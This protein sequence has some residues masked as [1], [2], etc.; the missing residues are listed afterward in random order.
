MRHTLLGAAALF[1]VAGT[2]NA[3]TYDID[4]SH[5]YPNFT[6]SHLGYSTTYGRFGSTS[7]TIEMDLAKKTG[8]V[9]IVIDAASID[10]GFKKRD[11]H[12]RS[13]DF[14]NVNEFPQIT[15]KSTK[16]KFTGDS[17]AKVEGKLTITGVTKDVTLD[18]THIHCGPHPFNKKDV[19]GF[20]AKTAIKRS[21]FGVK[22]ALP[23]VGDD[24]TIMIQAEGIKK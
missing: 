16:V 4:P 2:A 8:A 1:M 5:T 20:D 7:G 24:V 14:F 12:L 11:D 17:T 23:A 22:Y 3:A 19:C 18:V 6:I 21:E 9:D 10:T 13:P 15:F